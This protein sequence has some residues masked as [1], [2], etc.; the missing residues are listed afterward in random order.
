MAVL[1]GALS[2]FFVMT[3][4]AAIGMAYYRYRILKQAP[5]S[6]G[7]KEGSGEA[8]LTTPPPSSGVGGLFASSAVPGE[9]RKNPAFSLASMN[10]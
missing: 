3:L 9:V 5:P 4:L 7:E 6:S 8:E 1:P 10:A 2:G